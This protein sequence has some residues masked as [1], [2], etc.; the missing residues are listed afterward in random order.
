MIKKLTTLITLLLS[1]TSFTSFSQKHFSKEFSIYNDND[2]YTSVKRDRYYTNGLFLSYRYISKKANDHLE[3]KIYEIQ[4]GQEMYTPFKAI[5]NLKE[6]HDRPF[7]AHLF[8][9]FGI[10]RFYKN[11]SALNTRL[12]LGIIGPDA[13]GQELQDFIHSLYNYQQAIGWNY[14]IANAISVNFNTDYLKHLASNNTKTLDI[15]WTNKLRAGTIYTD[16]S[17]GLYGRIGFKPLQELFNS[18]AF[19]SNLNTTN[20]KT[21]NKPEAFLFIKPMIH[22]VLYDATIQGSFLNDNNPVTF[23]LRP[24]TFTTQ[25]GIQFTANRFNFGYFVNYH[26]KKLKS[27]RVPNANFYGTILIN[28]Q[29]N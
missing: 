7:A 28:Y 6:N 27:A 3:K 26:S 11:K 4:I 22:Y 9:S 5:V 21:S 29:F 25:V 20:S 10:N 17:T 23:E 24:I 19:S 2:L 15:T 16:I 1:F 8:G 14:Q 18:I 12:Q 13:L